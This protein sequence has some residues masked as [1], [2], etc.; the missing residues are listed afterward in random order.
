MF[1]TYADGLQI[2]RSI[3]VY[4]S[5]RIDGVVVYLG[6]FEFLRE[7]DGNSVGEV[8]AEVIQIDTL[9][10]VDSRRNDLQ[11][12]GALLC[13]QFDG[14]SVCLDEIFAIEN[15]SVMEIPVTTYLLFL[16]G[17][18]KQ[19]EQGDGD[20]CMFFHL[21]NII[22]KSRNEKILSIGRVVAYL[23][24]FIGELDTVV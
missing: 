8:H 13:G 14:V 22:L 24:V 19:R 4:D 12:D 16:T 17:T 21:F 9:L 5:P 15:I 3:F 1:C 23:I 18:A 2:A 7:R 20:G 6:L 10:V 11:I